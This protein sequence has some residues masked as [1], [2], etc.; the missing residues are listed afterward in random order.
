M[1]ATVERIEYDPNR[2]CHIML[3]KYENIYNKI[4]LV[5]AHK[6][7]FYSIYIGG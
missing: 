3:I 2:T 4:G 6:V 7:Y 5:E 1:K